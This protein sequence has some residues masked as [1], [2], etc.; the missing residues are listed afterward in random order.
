[1]KKEEILKKVIERAVD[2]GWNEDT[3]FDDISIGKMEDDGY[4][5]CIDVD[6]AL[7][8]NSILFDHSFAKAFWGNDTPY[9][10]ILLS[11]QLPAWQYHI[12]QL[13]LAED[14]LKYMAG[15]LK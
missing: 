7:H 6:S 11:D 9:N 13:A 8:I 3:F 5:M 15:F 4:F 1:M 12:Q 14:R 10:P 2:N